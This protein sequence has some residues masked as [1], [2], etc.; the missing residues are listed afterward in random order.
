MTVQAL[1][2]RVPFVEGGP[3]PLLAV[4]GLCYGKSLQ[5]IGRF[6]KI[7]CGFQWPDQRIEPNRRT[8]N[9]LVEYAEEDKPSQV[10]TIRC[11]PAGGTEYSQRS[12]AFVTVSTLAAAPP[13]AA[14]PTAASL[15]AEAKLHVPIAIGWV[16]AAQARLSGVRSSIA[17]FK[18]YSP[19]ELALALP[20]KTHFKINIASQT[21]V[22]A[23]SR[24]SSV[25]QMFDL[26][27]QALGVLGT[28]MKGDP[29]VS[30]KAVAPLGGFRIPGEVITIGK[31]F[32]GAGSSPNLKAAVLIHE[33][34]HF[35]EAK[36]G[37]VASERPAPNGTAITDANGKVTNPS[38][39]NYGQMDFDLALRN[40]YS[41]AQCAAHCGLG[42]D[43]RPV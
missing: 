17:R 39:K 9:R 33:C 13:P 32:V 22:V 30:D 15:V 14:G 31:D 20:F 24:L 29:N 36:C 37:H 35:V 4:D 42:V 1:L 40:A 18:V 27:L 21:D 8:W 11:F 43:Q 19:A 10:A 28:R 25:S 34:A 23:S 26:I 7:G 6:Q 16:T 12:S 38:A 5:A 3:S 41:F 2:D